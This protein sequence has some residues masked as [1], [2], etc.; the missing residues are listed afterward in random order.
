MKKIRNKGVSA[1][2]GVILMVA[3]TVAIAGTVYFYVT[4][5]LVKDDLLEYDVHKNIEGNLTEITYSYANNDIDYFLTFDNNKTY[6]IY[7]NF[8]W[9][10]ENYYSL[11]IY[12]N[13]NYDGWFIKEG[14]SAVKL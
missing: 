6:F 8:G 5:L 7:D 3:I 11:T 2:I 13:S 9:E 14:T 10:L 4:T 1:V 12:T